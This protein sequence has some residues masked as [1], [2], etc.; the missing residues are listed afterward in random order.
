MLFLVTMIYVPLEYINKQP[1]IFWI[2][3]G[4]RNA[5]L[6]LNALICTVHKNS[7]AQFSNLQEFIVS[8]GCLIH[9]TKL[10]K[11]LSTTQ[12]YNISAVPSLVALHGKACSIPKLKS[13]QL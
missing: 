9:C 7:Q 8:Y 11:Q 10:F 13:S 3:K 4:Y 1:D 2:S 5:K 12:L 6:A